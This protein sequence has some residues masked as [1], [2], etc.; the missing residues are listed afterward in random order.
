MSGIPEEDEDIFPRPELVIVPAGIYAC[1]ITRSPLKRTS[2]FPGQE[3]YYELPL[4]IKD[5]AGNVFKYSHTFSLKSQIY[6]QIILLVGGKELPTGQIDVPPKTSII[7]KIFMAE[8]IKRPWKNNRDKVM[9]DILR[10]WAYEPHGTEMGPA[11]QVESAK[12]K[13][14][15]PQIE[16]EMKPETQTESVK[17]EDEIIPF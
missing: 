4:K 12:E 16:S 7:G 3:Y 1:Q 8:V 14:P 17:E 13:S 10:V 11:L 6:A 15:D 9:N 5:N 2:Q